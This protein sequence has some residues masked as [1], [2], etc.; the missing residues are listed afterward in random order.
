MRSYAIALCALALLFSGK[1]QANPCDDMLEAERAAQQALTDV[2]PP[3]N[4]DSPVVLSRALTGRP[5]DAELRQQL[6]DAVF[7]TEHNWTCL[8]GG[9]S[10]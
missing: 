5:T 4:E 3:A 8:H 10:H 7:A 6:H 9:P 2:M 1:A